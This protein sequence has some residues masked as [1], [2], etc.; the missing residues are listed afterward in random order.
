ML[1]LILTLLVGTFLLMKGADYL[2][3]GSSKLARR[4]GISSLVT[5]LTIVALATS[6]PEFVVSTTAAIRGSGDLSIG[7]IIGSN[8]SNI[9]LILSIAAIIT[10]LAVK[11]STIWKEIPFSLFAV[12]ILAVQANDLFFSDGT[13]NIIG[14][15][16]GMVM[17]IF[18]A[19]YLYYVVQLA[20]RERRP[21]AEKLEE[22]RIAVKKR[23][24]FPT[25]PV[26]LL[27]FQIIGGLLLLVAGGQALV[28]GGVGIAR[29]LGVSE[30]VIGLT[31]VAIGTSLPEL[32][33]TAVAAWRKETDIA[34]GNIVGTNIFNILFVLGATAV[35]RP[36]SFASVF[37]IDI[38]LL[39]IAT[40]ILLGGILLFG[41]RFELTR[42][43]GVLFLCLYIL[44]VAFVYFRGAEAL[45]GGI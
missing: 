45:A 22:A 35:I 15:G 37:N 27:V 30:A 7:T 42:A 13:T 40:V 12:L 3:T 8:I 20:K 4:L 1:L 14:R 32:G 21:I 26:A 6:L 2:V 43:N 38:F 23:K 17:L 29:T 34:I 31:I 18:F 16:N 9:L 10:P 5:G 36:L 24:W 11:N 28:Y 25:G 19:L 33:A 41:K 39:V 44:Y